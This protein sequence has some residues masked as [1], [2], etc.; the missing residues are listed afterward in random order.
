MFWM[1][2]APKPWLSR[3]E[4]AIDSLLQEHE[5]RV[6]ELRIDPPDAMHADAR[7]TKVPSQALEVQR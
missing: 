6:A 3:M 4:P 5:R 7:D 2:V 1:G